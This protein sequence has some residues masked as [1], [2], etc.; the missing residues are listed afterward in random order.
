M[1]YGRIIQRDESEE[2]ANYEDTVQ[3]SEEN[4]PKLKTPGSI[5]EG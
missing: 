4:V 2:K 1:I 5:Y 3:K